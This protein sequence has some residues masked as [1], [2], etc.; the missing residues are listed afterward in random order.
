MFSWLHHIVPTSYSKI[1]SLTLQM[2]DTNVMACHLVKLFINGIHT[3]SCASGGRH[4]LKRLKCFAWHLV[5]LHRVLLWIKDPLEDYATPYFHPLSKTQMHVSD[6]FTDIPALVQLHERV[7]EMTCSFIPCDRRSTSQDQRLLGRLYTRNL[8]GRRDIHHRQDQWK[9]RAP[10]DIPSNEKK[11][12]MTL[13]QQVMTCHWM[14]TEVHLDDKV[15][16]L[17]S[18]FFLS[19]LM[20]TMTIFNIF[21]N[22]CIIASITSKGHF[23]S[24]SS[25]VVQSNIDVATCQKPNIPFNFIIK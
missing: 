12:E 6:R 5:V 23:I 16:L 17:Q 22:C 18:V 13:I 2:A 3:L 4:F 10:D 7:I 14:A 1:V 9:P 8:L 20:Y 15:S 25:S 21:K 11:G 19:S 24:S